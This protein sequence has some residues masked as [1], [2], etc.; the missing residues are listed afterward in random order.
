MHRGQMQGLALNV[1]RRLRSQEEGEKLWLPIPYSCWTSDN[2]SRPIVYARRGYYHV[3]DGCTQWKPPEASAA[4]ADKEKAVVPAAAA[5]LIFFPDCKEECMKKTDCKHLKDKRVIYSG[6]DHATTTLTTA[7]VFS[8]VLYHQSN[9]ILNGHRISIQIAI[10]VDRRHR[11]NDVYLRAQTS[12]VEVAIDIIPD[13]NVH[14]VICEAIEE[15]AS[16]AL[17]V[18]WQTRCTEGSFSKDGMSIWAEPGAEERVADKR[19]GELMSAITQ[20]GGVLKDLLDSLGAECV[21]EFR[22]LFGDCGT[23]CFSRHND[24]NHHS[25]TAADG[26]VLHFNAAFSLDYK[27]GSQPRKLGSFTR[28]PFEKSVLGGVLKDI[29]DHRGNHH[30]LQY[31]LGRDIVDIHYGRVRGKDEVGV[32]HAKRAELR[33]WCVKKDTTGPDGHL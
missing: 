29:G 8:P 9:D 32:R 25:G 26:L 11:Q 2:D 28:Q 31:A 3:V 33:L 24:T 14:R 7:V 27:P 16:I 20:D 13:G 22:V 1:Y 12:P 4:G 21:D 5:V 18:S 15:A 30:I 23:S 6:F 10:N 17:D 19:R